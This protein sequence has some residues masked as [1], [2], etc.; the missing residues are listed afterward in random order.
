MFFWRVGCIFTGHKYGAWE[1]IEGHAGVFR[2]C[3]KCMKN[4]WG[5]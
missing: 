2:E 1:Q 3:E 5:P 4:Q